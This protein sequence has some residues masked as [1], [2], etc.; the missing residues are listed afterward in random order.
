MI[1]PI[2]DSRDK[3]IGYKDRKKITYD[4]IY[5]VSALWLTN[6]RGEFLLAKRA[7]DKEH[8]PGKWGPAVAGTV[9]KD[10]TYRKNIEKEISE[11]LGIKILPKK[12]I[13]LKRKTKWHY[14]CQWYTAKI[15]SN[16]KF[17]FNK[18]EIAE[19]RWFNEKDFYK[20]YSKN[21]DSFLS[22]IKDY[23]RQFS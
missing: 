5:R 1:I 12:S 15:N 20:E 22:N 14:F 19:I 17:S 3:I 4:D 21:P 13:K 8:D 23:V 10:E 7:L 9:E 16:T 2:V 11:E 6:E 18:S